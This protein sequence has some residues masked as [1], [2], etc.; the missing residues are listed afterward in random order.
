MPHYLVLFVLI[1]YCH[2][3]SISFEYLIATVLFSILLSFSCSV[4]S[5]YFYHLLPVTSRLSIFSL[6]TITTSFSIISTPTLFSYPIYPSSHSSS[7]P[8]SSPAYPQFPSSY[9][10]QS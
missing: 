2:V 8:T 6:F 7:P 3:L 5:T 4:R 1:F 10:S 9:P